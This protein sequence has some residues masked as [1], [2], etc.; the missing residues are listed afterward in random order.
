MI[1]FFFF[2]AED[3]IRDLYVTGVQT[4]ALPIF[5]QFLS[6][7][8]LVRCQH[9]SAGKVLGSGGRKIG[10]AHLRWVFGEAACLF[11]RSSERAK[12]W[13]QRQAK[14]RG[15]GKALAILAARLGRAVYHLWRKREAFDEDRFWQGSGVTA[16]A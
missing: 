6:Y 9:E 2:Q 7:C 13:K 1:F 15:E 12:L 11:L 14:K 8:R 4:C 10:N 5:G 16:K 3:G